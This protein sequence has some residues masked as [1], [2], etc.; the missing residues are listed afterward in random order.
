MLH[1]I[2]ANIIKTHG[3]APITEPDKDPHTQPNA[4]TDDTAC[5]SQ[6]DSKG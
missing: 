4:V 3:F 6:N 2:F 5:E 1:P